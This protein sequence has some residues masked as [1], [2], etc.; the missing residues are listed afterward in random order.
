MLHNVCS[1]TERTVRAIIG[2]GL[3]SML[4]FLEAPVSYFGLIG[5]VPIATAVFRY[6]PISHMLGVNT[7]RM[8]QKHA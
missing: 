2:L 3:L 1:K 5:L 7:C 6:C 8:E 4:F